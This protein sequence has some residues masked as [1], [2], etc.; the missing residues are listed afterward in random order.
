MATLTRVAKSAPATL[1]HTFIVGETATDPTS[2]AATVTIVDANGTNVVGPAAATRTGTG[3]YTYAMAGQPQLARYTVTWTGTFSG[4]AVSEVDYVEIVGAFLF[5]LATARGS[6]S[7][8]ADSVKFPTAA[9][10]VARQ[11]VEDECEMICDRA[12]VP[13]YRRAVLDGSGSPDVML[14]DPLWALE[15]R[16]AADIRLI[17]SVTMAPQANQ[18]FVAFTSQQLAALVVTADGMLRRVDGAIWTEGVA[19]IVVEYEYGWDAGPTDLIRAALVRL[20]SRL[21]IPL[22]GIP[23]NATSFVAV[24]GGTFRLDL[25]GRHKT[26][27]PQVDGPYSRYSRRSGAG[28][29]TGA[30]IPASRT[31][32]YDVQTNSLFHQRL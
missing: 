14:T 15:G 7:A 12:F 23:D 8:L 20:R 27:L 9:L 29:G 4:S 13:R 28:T 31:L 5:D 18:T 32:S 19:N 2:N 11:E 24:D 22:T 3:V 1:S 21:A 30:M 10:A 26:G 25:P 16:S 17:R 6:D